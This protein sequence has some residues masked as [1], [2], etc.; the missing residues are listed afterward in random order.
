MYAEMG[1]RI[2]LSQNLNGF[3]IIGYGIIIKGFTTEIC[4]SDL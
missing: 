4:Y 3:K 1:D 2:T